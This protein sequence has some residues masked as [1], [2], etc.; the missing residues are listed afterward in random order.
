MTEGETIEV[1]LGFLGED[2]WDRTDEEWLESL[3]GYIGM[4]FEDIIVPEGGEKIEF[5]E[6][7]ESPYIL[8]IA[9]YHGDSS[10]KVYFNS[11]QA[12]HNAAKLFEEKYGGEDEQ[13]DVKSTDVNQMSE[14]EFEK[15]KVQQA[16]LWEEV[17]TKQKLKLEE[18]Q[19]KLK[20][21]QDSQRRA[22]IEKN[23]S[24]QLKQIVAAGDDYKLLYLIEKGAHLLGKE[25]VID[26]KGKV[27]SKLRQNP[28]PAVIEEADRL[29]QNEE[30]RR[31]G[32]DGAGVVWLPKGRW[33]AI[34]AVIEGTPFYKKMQQ[35]VKPNIANS[36]HTRMILFMKDGDPHTR[37]ELDKA[38]GNV[39]PVLFRLIDRGWIY[40]NS[41][42]HG[43]R[44]TLNLKNKEVLNFLGISDVDVKK[45]Y[46]CHS[47]NI[48]KWGKKQRAIGLRQVWKCKD[49]GHKFVTSVE[50]AE[51]YKPESKESKRREEQEIIETP[52]WLCELCG[53][54][55][56]WKLDMDDGKIAYLC[57]SDY[58]KIIEMAGN[59]K[60]D[61]VVAVTKLKSEIREKIETPKE[62]EIIETPI[63]WKC[64][65]PDCKKSG[66]WE[67][68]ATSGDAEKFWR[69][70]MG[71]S[72]CAE[73]F[74]EFNHDKS[75][76]ELSQAFSRLKK[77][78]LAK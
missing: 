67:L 51:F 6:G 19:A 16:K 52:I 33:E 41:A 34:K 26:Y 62:Q 69:G 30:L 44:F 66:V 45:C 1:S 60:I 73:H 21:E 36:T 75:D 38:V 43:S 23:G 76:V 7:K 56:E 46:N 61:D 8:D 72:L 57:A 59:E 42:K 11:R 40:R 55:A 14:E 74:E 71:F 37:E 77:R 2:F 27:I 49:C 20:L 4:Y 15:W 50:S 31:Q 28:S 48:V 47:K 17:Q 5:G 12:L 39:Y 58:D 3:P 54:N 25:Y 78:R 9:R 64:V 53:N 70:Y 22:W 18:E 10:H 29:N 24:E 32:L 35:S 63:K 65:V 13:E 68:G